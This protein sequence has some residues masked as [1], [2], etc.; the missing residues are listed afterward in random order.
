MNML[1][2][3][4]GNTN[5]KIGL[6]IDDEVKFIETAPPDDEQRLKDL[7]TSAWDSIPLSKS[8]R[9]PVKDG[10]IVVCSV[11]PD[12]TENIRQLC[13]DLLGEK[14]K[15]I[16][17]DLPLPIEVGLAEPKKVGIDRLVTAAAAFAVVENAVVVADLGTAVTIDLVDE[18][19]VFMGGIIAPGFDI[20]AKALHQAT[21]A[22]PEVKFEK[23]LSCIGADTEQAIRAGLYYSAVGLLRTVTEE[24]ANQI[25]TWPQLIVTGSAAAAI[26]EDCDFVDNWVPDLVVRGIFLAYKKHLSDK[27]QMGEI[28]DKLRREKENE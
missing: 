24:Y 8:A 23:P 10:V 26:K 12:R 13:D 9:E 27:N 6:F 11:V 25:G 7:I 17:T 5:Y 16:G 20:S 2:I 19:G 3:D 14:V 4:I 21:A 22:L 18:Q 28:V 15:V 1:A